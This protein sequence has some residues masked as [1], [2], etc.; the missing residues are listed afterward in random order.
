MPSDPA[1]PEKPRWMHRH[2]APHITTLIMMAGLAALNMN[3]FLPSLPS[4]AVF[5]EA[6]Y[7]VVSI[8]VSGYLA[9]TAALQL[10]VGPLSDR[11]GRRPVMLGSIGIFLVATLGCIL[12]QDVWTFL[13]FRM[14]QAAVATGMVLSRAVVRDLVDQDRAASMIGYVTMGM[15]LMPMIGPSIGGWLDTFLVW[16]A[17]FVFTAVMGVLVMLLVWFDM[18]ETN[19]TNSA[20]MTAQF[21]QYPGLVSSHRFWGYA[22]V[23]AFASGAFFA[24]LGGGPY[25]SA[26]V[27]GIGP[28]QV[29]FYFALIAVGYMLGNLF[30]GLYSVRVWR[31][32]T[33]IIG[34]ILSTLGMTGGLLLFLL[35][36]IHP[37]SLFGAIF[38]VGLGNGL[39][40]PASLA[41]IVSVRPSLAGSASGLGGA[42]MIG[43]GAAI[44][45]ITGALLGPGAGPYPLLLMM[46]GS[47]VLSVLAALYVLYIARLRAAE[48]AGPGT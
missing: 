32:R 8:A 48:A 40:M 16:Q 34:S 29:G 30:S 35:G 41:G 14:L 23:A 21:R 2:S 47:S 3:V 4:M 15:A 25:V 17:N 10:F 44:S 22:E 11:F 38:F 1:R 39:S 24:F 28:A 18:G 26:E 6:D 5:F 13:A 36:Y 7:A 27:L 9:M 37:M 33:M 46:L 19:Q 43:G 42:V 31:I 20:S 45:A 12:A